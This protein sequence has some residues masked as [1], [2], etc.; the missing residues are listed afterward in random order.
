MK[1]CRMGMIIELNPMSVPFIA[2]REKVLDEYAQRFVDE[3]Y[4]HETRR[5]YCEQVSLDLG[6]KRVTFELMG[7]IRRLERSQR[8]AA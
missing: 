3:M 6:D 2:N 4:Q 8:R 7:K 1:G 5:D